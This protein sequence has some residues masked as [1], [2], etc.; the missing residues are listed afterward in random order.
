[1]ILI[2]RF[3]QLKAMFTI[4]FVINSDVLYPYSPSITFITWMLPCCEQFVL[5]TALQV[6]QGKQLRSLKHIGPE[7]SKTHRF[8]KFTAAGLL[9]TEPRIRC[10]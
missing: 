8:V 10:K 6:L 2:H 3:Y 5:P 9:N 4:T 7:G 1:M